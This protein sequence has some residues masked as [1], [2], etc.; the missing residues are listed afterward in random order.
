MEWFI[1]APDAPE[2]YVNVN[3]NDTITRGK[4]I[5]NCEAL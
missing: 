5:R 4:G 1:F 2:L 3:D